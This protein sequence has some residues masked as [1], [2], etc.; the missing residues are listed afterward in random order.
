[1]KPLGGNSGTTVRKDRM[2]VRL[3]LIRK[4]GPID[5]TVGWTSAFPGAFPTP[6]RTGPAFVVGA[7]ANF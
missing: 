7:A 6:W 3:D 4:F 1:F 2:D 5:V